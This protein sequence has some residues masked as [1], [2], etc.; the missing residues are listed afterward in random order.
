[1][2]TTTRTKRFVLGRRHNGIVMSPEEFDA[3]TDCD[4]LYSYE[5][6][7]GVVIVNPIPSRFER[8]PNDELGHWLRNYQEQHPGFLD[9]TVFDEYIRTK[10]SRRRADRVIWAGLGRGPDPETDV[11]TIA[12]ELVSRRRR[13][14]QRDYVEKRD[15]YL[16]TGV[17]EYWV[18]NRFQR[19]MTVFRSG[20]SGI[21]E[22]IVTDREIYKTALLPGF[23]LPLGKL[24]SVCDDW[25]K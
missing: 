24:L 22:Q 11:P 10:S 17:V 3:I 1:M 6:I 19:T 5:L 25:K 12:I 18:I 13:D 8:D 4:D 15:E 21:E 9:K 16:A 14:W 7:H 23:E 20:V 2:S